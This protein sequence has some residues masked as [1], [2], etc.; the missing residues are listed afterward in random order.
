MGDLNDLPVEG[1]IDLPALKKGG[2]L[3]GRKLKLKILGTG[4]LTKALT[5]RADAFSKGAIEK[6]ESAAERWR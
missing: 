6:I 5:I 4:E 3:V 1:V 2:L